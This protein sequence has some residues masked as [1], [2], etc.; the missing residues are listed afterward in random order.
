MFGDNRSVV[1]SSAIPHSA[2]NKRWNAL[3]HHHVC[4]AIA[5]G[6]P[7]F[8]HL[9]GTENPADILTKPLAWFVMRVFV[10]P[11]LVWKG[12]TAEHS[13]GGSAPE[14]SDT[15]PGLESRRVG[16]SAVAHSGSHEWR[17]VNQGGRNPNASRGPGG[18]GAQAPNA[19]LSSDQCAVLGE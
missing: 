1:A 3:S 19:A 2:L 10:E 6:W 7:R 18:A 9:P 5:S 16:S 15:D 8:E 14:G 4:E 12:D 13:G 11:M 17:L